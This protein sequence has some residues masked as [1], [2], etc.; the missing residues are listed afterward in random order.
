MSEMTNDRRDCARGIIGAYIAEEAAEAEKRKPHALMLAPHEL[1]PLL[2]G[3]SV[4]LA[5]D[6]TEKSDREPLRWVYER[7]APVVHAR[8]AA[9]LEEKGGAR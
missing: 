9:K 3:L 6:R 2:R 5:S 4:A 8:T 1:W 7:L